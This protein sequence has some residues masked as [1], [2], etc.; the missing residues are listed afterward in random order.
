MGIEGRVERLEQRAGV[1]AKRFVVA[2][3]ILEGP[4]VGCYR[5]TEAGRETVMTETQVDELAEQPHLMLFRVC[6][7]HDW[8]GAEEAAT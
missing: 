6:Y 5:V 2:R 4:D 3:Q 7:T 8:S 1:G